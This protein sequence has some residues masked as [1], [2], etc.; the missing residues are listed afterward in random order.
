MFA[1]PFL[2]VRSRPALGRELRTH[3]GDTT[4]KVVSGD[5]RKWG[6]SKLLWGL[7]KWAL[8]SSRELKEGFLEEVALSRVS[9]GEQDIN[10]R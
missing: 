5:K 1:E 10:S 2:W 8:N 4:G 9:E 6:T 3:S 7:R